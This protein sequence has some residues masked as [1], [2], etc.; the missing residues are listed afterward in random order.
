MAFSLI[1]PLKRVVPL[2][3]QIDRPLDHGASLGGSRIFGDSRNYAG[4]IL[5]L[6]LALSWGI[7]AHDPLVGA[8]IML[9]F[10]GAVLGSFIKRRFRLRSGQKMPVLDQLDYMFVVGGIWYFFGFESGAVVCM[11]M[12]I[13]LI[14]QPTISYVAFLLRLKDKPY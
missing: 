1:V 9:T 8:K 7:A 4:L 6:V 13:T 2:V 10:V 3:A 5:A 12:L 11:A 14:G